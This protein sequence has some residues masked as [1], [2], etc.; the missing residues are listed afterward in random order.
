MRRPVAALARHRIDK[1]PTRAADPQSAYFDKIARQRAWVT[2]T[3]SL[4]QQLGQLAC[5]RTSRC[6]SNVMILACRAAFVRA[7]PAYVVT[8][9]HHPCLLIEEGQ[10]SLLHVSAVLGLVPDRRLWSVDHRSIDL[11]AAIGGQAVQHDC[12]LVGDAQQ[13]RGERVRHEDR[14]PIASGAP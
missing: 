2:C 3:P 4:G 12:L 7:A 5:D 6:S 9:L 8:L 13:G 10:E 14:L 11:L 1:V